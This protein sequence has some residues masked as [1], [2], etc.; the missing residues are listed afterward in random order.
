MHEPHS[1]YSILTLYWYEAYIV[2]LLS[3]SPSTIV[4]VYLGPANLYSI[5]II[6]SFHLFIYIFYC[7]RLQTHLAIMLSLFLSLS[8]AL[9][10]LRQVSFCFYIIQTASAESAWIIQSDMQCLS[11]HLYVCVC[12]E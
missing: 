8:P 10:L 2:S 4:Y 1:N 6:I 11:V 9:C 7:I 3:F 12:D 5:I